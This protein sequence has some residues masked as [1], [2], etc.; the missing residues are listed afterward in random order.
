MQKAFN[1]VTFLTGS[2]ETV[3]TVKDTPARTPF[4]KELLSFLNDVSGHLMHDPAARRYPDVITFAFW[5][6][7]S[8][9]L[10]LKERF[11]K[12][13]GAFRLGRGTAFHIAPSNVPV[14]F[15]YS[16]AAG[17]LTGNTNIVRV[18][19]KE[20]EQVAILSKAF[21]TVLERYEALK[22]YVSL[23]RYARDKEVNDLFSSMADLRVV[24]GG[25]GT[26]AQLRKSPLPPRAVE[27]AFAD[28]YSLSVIDSD[29]YLSMSEKEGIA[30]DFYNDTYLFD[31]NACTSPRMVVWT[32]SRIG[33]AKRIFWAEAHRLVRERYSLQAIQAVNKLNAACLAAAAF[34]GC[35]VPEH[36]DNLILRVHVPE[37]NASLMNYRENSGFFFE[38]DCRDILE[39]RDL[40]NDRHCQTIG[41]LGDREMFL[42]LLASGIKGVDR[43]VP[44][45]HT[46]DFD[47]IWD[48][49]NL[50]EV[51]T[52]GISVT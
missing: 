1:K 30:R 42:P 33:E 52:R 3:L 10:R 39:L 32:G 45:G 21:Q 25:D 24:W 13:D 37:A 4:D 12:E 7:K 14:N 44:L 16:L 48:G 49:Y 11:F 5:I 23:V 51:M 15:A 22:P 29:C 34:P 38:Y 26:I 2:P 18:P 50:P 20:F 6:R 46:M 36:E 17:L 9:L 41:Y 28:R 8:A 43:I 31:Q 47:L 40:C 19:S 35:S 27:I